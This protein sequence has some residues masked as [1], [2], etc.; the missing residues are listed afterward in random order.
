MRF[1]FILDPIE[2]LLPH[3][4]TSFV[5]MLEAQARGHELYYLRIEQLS[6]RGGT[7]Q[8]VVRRVEVMRPAQ[9]GDP[10][11][12]L[13]EERCEALH[14]FDAVFMRKDPPFDSTYLYATQI[15]SLADP[16]RT[17]VLNDPRGL[18][19]ANEKLYTLNFDDVMPPTL[20]TA[21]RTQ[22]KEFLAEVGGDMIVKPLDGFG[23]LGIFHVHSADRNLNA[24]LETTTEHGR[25]LV[26]AQRYLPE[27]RQGDKRIIVLDG[28]PLGALLRVPRADDNRGNMA[29]GGSAEKG[30][31]TA[32]DRA[33]CE[34]VAPRLARDGLYFVG[35]DVIG[36][37]LTEVNVTSP[38]G[39]QEI[40]R[41]DGVRLEANVI[42]FVEARIGKPLPN[43][44]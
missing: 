30:E 34:R 40:N 37:Y 18:R 3:H 39:V 4:D 11:F 2:R 44:G 28:K 10:H 32:R 9:P 41:H 29:V 20:V 36:G 12:V 31:L 38:T 16:R 15:L 1:A 42:D 21:D 14:F 43:L 17:L 33:I 24:I 22:L 13:L 19:D 8:A 25:R 7:P 23:G 6:A 26:M 27:V 5:L 35:L